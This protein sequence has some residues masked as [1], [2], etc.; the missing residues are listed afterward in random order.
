[1]A[2]TRTPKFVGGGRQDVDF[3]SQVVG[4]ARLD[5]LRELGTAALLGGEEDVAGIA[6]EDSPARAGR[7][8]STCS[9]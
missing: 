9:S 6:F 1:M 4:D 2:P 7:E 3:D 5:L 8:I